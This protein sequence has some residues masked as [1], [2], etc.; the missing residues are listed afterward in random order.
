MDKPNPRNGQN[1]DFSAI[2]ADIAE[3]QEFSVN[4]R[5]RH[6]RKK[7]EK[8]QFWSILTIFG[9]AQGVQIFFSKIDRRHEL[10]L[11]AIDHHTKK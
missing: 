7:L 2:F 3:K 10:D 1:G 6:F 11:M 9:H 8:P 5:I 4:D